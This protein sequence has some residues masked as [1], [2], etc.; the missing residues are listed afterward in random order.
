VSLKLFTFTLRMRAITDLKDLLESVG[1]ADGDGPTIFAGLPRD[2][3]DFDDLHCRV[4]LF[5]KSRQARLESTIIGACVDLDQW[6]P[7]AVAL[8]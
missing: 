8:R 3:L 2:D 5:S 4:P 6:S 1:V 7:Q